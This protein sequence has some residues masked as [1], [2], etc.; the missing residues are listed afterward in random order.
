VNTS[1]TSQSN[2]QSRNCSR[3]PRNIHLQHSITTS[4]Y[5]KILRHSLIFSHKLKSLRLLQHSIIIT[6]LSTL[7][8]PHTESHQKYV[9]T[10]SLLPKC[11]STSVSSFPQLA[12]I[13]PTSSVELNTQ[14]LLV[15]TKR[16]EVIESR[17]PSS[18]ER[19]FKFTTPT[20]SLD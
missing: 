5:S 17:M 12:S 1:K 14:L 15:P 2:L 6:K 16:S 10:K 4:N 19:D 13:N 3:K 9:N 8:L 7:N 11:Q 20:C 18:P